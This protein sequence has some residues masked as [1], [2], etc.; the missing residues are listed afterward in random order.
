MNAKS[1]PAE[2]PIPQDEGLRQ[3]PKK[4]I[5]GVAVLPPMD[6]KKLEDSRR[7]PIDRPRS[8]SPGA[9]G[10]QYQ[11]SSNYSST[12]QQRGAS[13][14]NEGEVSAPVVFSLFNSLFKQ[15]ILMIFK[16]ANARRCKD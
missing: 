13:H 11:E 10:Q 14:L 16:L 7:S 3:R 9:T 12:A 4:P 8:K 15:L 1:F 2:S 5:G 6:L